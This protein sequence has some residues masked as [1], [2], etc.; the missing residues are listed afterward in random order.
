MRDETV[1]PPQKQGRVVGLDV[2]RG[3][4]M[5]WI[6]GA[7]SCLRMLAELHP[8]PVFTFLGDQMRHVEWEGFHF[9]DFIF[10]LFIF[11][12]GVSMVYSLDKRL[13]RDSKA[14]VY[15]HVAI[16]AALLY[17][18]GIIY[19]GGVGGF[20]ERDVLWGV[21]NRFGLC[22]LAAGY[23]YCFF[24]GQVRV[25]FGVC[26]G[27][28]LAY[29][30]LLCFVPVPGVGEVSLTKDVNWVRYIDEKLPPYYG[31]SSEGFLSTFPAIAGCLCGVFAGLYLKN[32][33]D[34]PTRKVAVLMTV[35]ALLV[36]LG[37]LWGLHFWIVKELWSSSFVVLA[38]GYSCLLLGAFHWMVD[39]RRWRWWT[40]V[41]LWIGANSITLYMS[42]KF[43]D[44]NKVATYFVGGVVSEAAGDYAQLLQRMTAVVLAILLARFLYKR[45]I[46]LR[47]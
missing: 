31:F 2:L 34:N 33:S 41:F 9:Y 28:L 8:N 21:L 38:T 32:G 17:V 45:G 12:L 7:E 37:N 47:V 14:S 43:I 15:A 1:T 3:F 36:F 40:P 35:G 22:Y 16:R 26:V 13:A 29:W 19:Y 23:L 46:F 11:L 42:G 25:L 24:R 18:L 5:F 39:I 10:P 20:N 4:D 6:L 44:Y 30:V 27:I